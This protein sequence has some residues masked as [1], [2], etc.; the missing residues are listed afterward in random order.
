MRILII[1]EPGK[2]TRELQISPGQVRIGRDPRCDIV[3]D[4]PGVSRT[5]ARILREEVGFFVGDVGSR[6]GTLLNRRQL[7][8]ERLSLLRDGDVVQ[9]GH[10]FLRL[11]PMIRRAITPGPMR[12]TTDS[13]PR[14]GTALGE[15]REHEQDGTLCLFRLEKPEATLIVHEKEGVTCRVHIDHD[16]VRIGRSPRSSIVLRDASVS[17]EHGEIVFNREGFHLVDRSADQETSLDGVRIGIARLSH[18]SF[19]RLGKV[20]LL[21]I[22]GSMAREASFGLRDHLL[23]LHADRATG[24]QAAFRES[25]EQGCDFAEELVFRAV[26]DPEEWWA[27]ASRFRAPR[28]TGSRSWPSRLLGRLA[29]TSRDPEDPG[30]PWP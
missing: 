19:I 29:A 20:R 4:D 8:P 30:L 7:P 9:I 18:R 16:R 22:L 10:S 1:Q 27:A 15:R 17:K 23:A 2:G 13:G 25:R 28:D 14:S 3:L 26:L 12:S 24:I 11:G 21:F 6:N 5:H